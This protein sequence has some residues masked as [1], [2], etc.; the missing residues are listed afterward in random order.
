M[1]EIKNKKAIIQYLRDVDIK[2]YNFI[3]NRYIS[4][5][6]KLVKNSCTDVVTKYLENVWMQKHTVSMYTISGADF[7][8]QFH[9]YLEK[10]MKMK[11]DTIKSWNYQ[12]FGRDMAKKIEEGCGIT[13][14]HSYGPSRTRA[15]RIDMTGLKQYLTTKG[16][17]TEETYMFLRDPEEIEN[18]DL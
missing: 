4:D 1:G 5:L 17:I 18:D 6:Y 10:N 7:L 2:D 8:D 14:L 3:K 15:Y 11:D 12:R 16:I 13:R 9:R